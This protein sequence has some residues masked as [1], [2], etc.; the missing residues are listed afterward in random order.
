M[1]A[2]CRV[3]KRLRRIYTYYIRPWR[4]SLIFATAHSPSCSL[5]ISQT[6][7]TAVMFEN[8]VCYLESFIFGLHADYILIQICCLAR[9]QI[10][11]M[12]K[13]ISLLIIKFK[14]VARLHKYVIFVFTVV[15]YIIKNIYTIFKRKKI[16]MFFS[17]NYQIDTKYTFHERISCFPVTVTLIFTFWFG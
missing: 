1:T 11:T 17:F 8:D 16:T 9:W 4:V 2:L 6:A 7:G 5:L 14:P 15:S 12:M 13:V 3:E 10:S